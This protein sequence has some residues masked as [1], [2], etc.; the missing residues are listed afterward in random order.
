MT[1]LEAI[2]KYLNWRGFPVKEAFMEYHRVLVRYDR[3]DYSE[4][5]LLIEKYFLCEVS[6][7]TDSMFAICKILA[8]GKKIEEWYDK[9]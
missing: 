3:T 4:V 1:K 9:S 6:F 5:R 7:Y 2:C 8:E